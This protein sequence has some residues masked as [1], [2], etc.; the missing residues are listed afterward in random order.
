RLGGERLLLVGRAG[1]G[2]R[3]EQ[4]WEQRKTTHG[5]PP[6]RLPSVRSC[7][8]NDRPMSKSCLLP[9]RSAY[10]RNCIKPA[11]NQA[12]TERIRSNPG[13]RGLAKHATDRP[14]SSARIYAG[15]EGVL[16]AMDPLA[17]FL[18]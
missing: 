5:Q 7:R 18:R 4:H 8:L 15:M 11:N 17:E 12:I 14:W 1:N 6:R 3:K 13:R 10:N 16:L 2:D 9:Q